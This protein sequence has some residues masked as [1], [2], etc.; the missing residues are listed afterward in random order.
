MLLNST[1]YINLKLKNMTYIIHLDI[2]KLEVAILCI[3]LL[4]LL[5]F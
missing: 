4:Q 2:V 5:A 3:S 1:I